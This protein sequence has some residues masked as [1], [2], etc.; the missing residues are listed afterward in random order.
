MAHNPTV[1]TRKSKSSRMVYPPRTQQVTDI[2]TPKEKVPK[3]ST[4]RDVQTVRRSKVTSQIIPNI[5]NKTTVK[6]VHRL[7]VCQMVSHSKT[8][9]RVA[10]GGGGGATQ[11]QKH[12]REQS[13]IPASPKTTRSVVTTPAVQKSTPKESRALKEQ[14]E[15]KNNKEHKDLKEAKAHKEPQ[16]K[17]A[18]KSPNLSHRHSRHQSERTKNYFDKYLKFAFDLSTPEGVKQLEAHFFPNKDL[19]GAGTSTN[20][21]E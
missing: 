4:P 13:Y 11:G 21:E 5:V 3:I 17:G 16:P 2:E 6:D 1:V 12:H 10:G 8:Q 18:D 15:I 19:S 20:R 14:T 7:G 9:A